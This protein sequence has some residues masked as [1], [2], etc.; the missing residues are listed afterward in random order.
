VIGDG[1]DGYGSCWV[2]CGRMCL[3]SS[4]RHI[5]RLGVCQQSCGQIMWSDFVY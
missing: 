1:D 2:L 3:L 4:A 5:S